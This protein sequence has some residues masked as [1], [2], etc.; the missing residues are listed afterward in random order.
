MKHMISLDQL[1]IIEEWLQLDTFN[2]FIS[3]MLKY[4]FGKRRETVFW[5]KKFQSGKKGI[6][7]VGE[8]VK[9]FQTLI[10]K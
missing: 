6:S 3:D 1:T 8:M 10:N 2:N 4:I 9:K 7:S 5:K